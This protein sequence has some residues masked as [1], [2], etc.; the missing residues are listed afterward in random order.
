MKV[1]A[2]LHIHSRFSRACSPRLTILNIAKW[3]EI[4][5]IDI[6]ATSDFTHP[7][8]LEEI[9]ENLKDNGGLSLAF[10]ALKLKISGQKEQKT[11]VG[12]SV[13][14]RFFIAYVQKWKEVISQKELIKSFKGQHAPQKFRAIGPLIN[15][16]EFYKNFNIKPEDKLYI[17]KKNRIKIW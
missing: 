16:S 2:D 3:A 15:N 14:Q 17:K 7:G 10:Q 11:I 6:V 12:L 4:K 13:Y 8:W 9:K 1:I 5:G